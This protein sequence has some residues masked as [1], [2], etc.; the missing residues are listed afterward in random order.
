MDGK[1]IDKVGKKSGNKKK[2]K[3]EYDDIRT[4]VRE[5]FSEI[6]DQIN[7][8]R[9]TNAPQPEDVLGEPRSPK[10]PAMSVACDPQTINNGQPGLCHEWK[11]CDGNGNTPGA[12]FTLFEF[13]YNLTP[14]QVYNQLGGSS[15]QPGDAVL[16]PNGEKL[17]YQG[18]GGGATLQSLTVMYGYTPPFSATAD[19]CIP[20][21]YGWRCHWKTSPQDMGESYNK[22]NEWA[23][24]SICVPGTAQNPGSFQ[25]KT[26]CIQSGC[27]GFDADRDKEFQI[28]PTPW[29]KFDVDLDE[30]LPGDFEI[31]E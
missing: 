21:N 26:E 6:V 20:M 30:E 4:Q 1:C 24:H 10:N 31:G 11:E 15:I 9:R 16:L 22:L 29:N 7:E 27:E 14:D 8:Q 25:T 2:L 19:S 23:P 28:D 17:V 12:A 3:K 18:A 5:I 13:Q